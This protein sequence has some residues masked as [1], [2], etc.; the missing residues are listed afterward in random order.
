MTISF[1]YNN[2]KIST[3]DID[4]TIDSGKNWFEIAKVNADNENHA[5]FVWSPVDTSFTTFKFYGE[6][7]CVLRVSASSDT[8]KS[9]E[10]IIIGSRP[11]SLIRPNQIDTSLPIHFPLSLPV[12]LI[13]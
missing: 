5:D 6:K 12:I 13:Y 7:I 10:F 2:K 8:L 1:D 11:A 4:G 3:I 9:S